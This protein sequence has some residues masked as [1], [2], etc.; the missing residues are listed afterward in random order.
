MK[1]APPL[2]FPA[3]AV[4]LI[5]AGCGKSDTTPPPAPVARTNVVV[6]SNL[7]AQPRTAPQT[8]GKID[9]GETKVQ[10]EAG[11]PD[12]QV[13]LGRAYLIG[14]RPAEA[15]KWFK[16]AA[17]QS[18]EAQ[19]QLGGLLLFGHKGAPTAAE[20]VTPNPPEGLKWTYTAATNGYKDA[21]RNMSKALEFGLGCSTNL[22]QAYAWI[23]LLA[24]SGDPVGRV[25]MNDMAIEISSDDIQ[26]VK[27][28]AEEIKAGRWPPLEIKRAG[29]KRGGGDVP[30]PL[31]LTGITFGRV[32]LAMING[33]TVGENETITVPR[34]KESVAI[35]CLKIGTNYVW[36]SVEGETEPRLL[37]T[38]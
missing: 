5:A 29:D 2:I 12:A 13:R 37:Q 30:L 20:M 15:L 19:F 22:P 24:D 34:G 9:L 6:R 25:M 11:D 3:L 32:P 21:Y 18:V 7:T 26:R 38:R 28:I 14:R 23:A 36:V 33:K 35:K 4:I 1:I 17:D 8:S 10:A 31:A 16:L 27:A